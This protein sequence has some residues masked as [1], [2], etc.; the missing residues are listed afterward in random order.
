MNSS[1][2]IGQQELIVKDIINNK[3]VKE[4]K[5]EDYPVIGSSIDSTNPFL[6]F[7]KYKYEKLNDL[8][9]N[10]DD[11]NNNI[12]DN[13][14]N[15]K[16][17]TS[18]LKW[19]NNNRQ[20]L[21]SN[22]TELYTFYRF[23][24][25]KLTKMEDYYDVIET[26]KLFSFAL[27]MT[28]TENLS[29]LIGLA[30][31][32]VI[33]KKHFKEYKMRLYVDFHSIFG[34][35]ETFNIFSMFIDIIKNIDPQYQNTLQIVVFFLNPYFN[36][37]NSSPYE[38]IV[39]DLNDIISYYNNIFYSTNNDY[40]KSPLLNMNNKNINNTMNSNTMNNNQNSDNKTTYV[41]IDENGLNI[42]YI[43]T[44]KINEKSTFA[45]FTCHIAVN[46]RFLPMNEN[47]EFHVRDLD[48]RL[49]LTDKKIIEKFN[50]PKYQYVPYYVFQFYKY[51]F[52]FLKWRI[53]VNP[54][55]AGCF[56]GNNRKKVMIS[57]ELRNSGNMKIL[58]KE[59]FFKHILFMSFNA[60][61]L[62]I[63]FLNDEFILANIFEKIKGKYSENILFLNM[64][65]YSNKHVNEY[66]YGLHNSDNYPCI[67]KLGV[68]IDIL[69]YKLNG[70]YV[71]IDPITD[72]KIGNISPKYN[73]LLKTLI[74]EQLNIYMNYNITETSN[75]ANKIRKNY[76][77]RLDEPI[78][79]ELESALFFSMVPKKFVIHDMADFNKNNYTNN[80][81][82]GQNFSSVGS[83]TN[84]VNDEKLKSINFMLCG[85][86]LSDVLENIIFPNSP[87]FIT[88][89][90]YIDDDNYDRLF[91]CL[92]FDEKTKSFL[93]KKITEKDISRKNIDQSYIDK[94]P[95]KYLS[96]TDKNKAKHSINNEF[97]EY[98]KTCQY[99]TSM[100]DYIEQMPFKKTISVDGVIIKTGIIVFIKKY[101]NKIYDKNNN[102]INNIVNNDVKMLQVKLNIGADGKF[103]IKTE[104]AVKN[105][106]AIH[107]LTPDGIVGKNTNNILNTI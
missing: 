98:L 5:N 92:Y 85:Y 15:M 4:S 9:K 60:S 71:T 96:F 39:V 62:Q 12:I 69:K 70:K 34:S 57:E 59:L 27:F 65:A 8:K 78:N 88:S 24:Y 42:E 56:G 31:N 81:L 103:G 94:I 74:T 43:K 2:N 32:F 25:Y 104:Q 63:G 107:G 49:N 105:F 90:K 99:N 47:C 54:Y 21:V 106:Q 1:Q 17:M 84:L 58:K 91:N 53:D 82:N 87:E 89:N 41:D 67:L 11:I 48:S 28:N 20:L 13:T 45:L 101:T 7:E 19:I 86:L 80:S 26:D 36:V 40:I 38:N 93:Q 52:P 51:Y 66:Y 75:I 61:N 10:I 79:D 76:K 50:S 37:N 73:K 3:K 95:D 64:G 83:S 55:L 72:F 46:L 35:P 33:M 30:Y 14:L 22:L 100:Y 97:N 18:Y 23:E 44:N 16:I 68:P 77:M 29:Y 102:V 6:P